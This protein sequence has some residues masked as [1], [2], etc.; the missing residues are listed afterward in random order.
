MRCGA[1]LSGL[2]NSNFEL[3]QVP[4][5]PQKLHGDGVVRPAIQSKE[6]RASA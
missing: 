2:A 6:K 3:W 4:V 5:I 1:F